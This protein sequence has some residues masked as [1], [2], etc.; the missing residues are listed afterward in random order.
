[1]QIDT[2]DSSTRAFSAQILSNGFVSTARL[3]SFVM[4]TDRVTGW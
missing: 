3:V 1:M 4:I 2:D